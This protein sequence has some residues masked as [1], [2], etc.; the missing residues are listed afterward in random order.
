[1]PQDAVNFLLA[2]DTNITASECSFDEL[3]HDLRNIDIGMKT[4]KLSSNLEETCKLKINLRKCASNSVYRSNHTSS[5]LECICIDSCLCSKTIACELNTTTIKS[6]YS[7][8][9]HGIHLDDKLT[10]L[11]HVQHVIDELRKQCAIVS[12]LRHYVPKPA[13]IDSTTIIPR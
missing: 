2:G 4:N 12:K 6:S 7:C 9:F 11:S 1:M 8:E 5:L 13:I 10:F 3:N